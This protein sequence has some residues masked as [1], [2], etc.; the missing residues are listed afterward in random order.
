MSKILFFF[1]SD[2]MDRRIICYL[3]NSRLARA[4]GRLW[5]ETETHRETERARQRKRQRE[6]ERDTKR[7][8][9]RPCLKRERQTDRQTD[10]GW[11]RDKRKEKVPSTCIPE[12]PIRLLTTSS[13]RWRSGTLSPGLC[14]HLHSNIHRT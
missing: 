3:V 5:R 1:H 12:T 9:R 14:G 11:G 13:K 2:G 4:K 8:E 10:R 7:K 6:T